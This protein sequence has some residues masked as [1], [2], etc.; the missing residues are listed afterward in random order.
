MA[1][2]GAMI[3]WNG[4]L[5]PEAQALVP[6]THIGWTGVA[7][8]FEGLRGY[9][10][11]DAEGVRIFRLREHLDRFMRSMKLMH[12]APRW[13]RDELA[14]A[15]VAVLRANAPREDIY[16]QPLAY[17]GDAVHGNFFRSTG[18]DIYIAQW[19][20]P[21]RLLTG[22]T[23]TACVSSYRRIGEEAMPPRVKN[24]SNYRNS[25]L[26]SREARLNGYDTALLLNG[27]GRVTEAPS[28]CVFLVRDGV[29]ITPDLAS[30]ILESITR[31]ALITL[32][33]DELGLAVQERA[34]DRTELYLA[35]EV[36]LTGNA[37][38]IQPLVAIDRLPIAAGGIGPVTARLGQLLRDI[39]RGDLPRYD[40]WITLAD[41]HAL[42]A[43][44]DAGVGTIPE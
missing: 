16:L 30:G 40:R 44:A 32:C 9:W 2:A 33:R 19:P 31:D 11:A 42:A 29:V 26:A 1:T 13:D 8:V 14:A 6:V 36:F 10:D 24:L 38:E 12:M 22:A 17:V 5:I 28:A 18:C 37:V 21:S 15:C 4:E 35:D 3:W 20:S 41:N 25:Q 7:G 27:A 34:V 39:V 23:A 43:G